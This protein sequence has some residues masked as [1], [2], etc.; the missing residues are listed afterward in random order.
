[1]PHSKA[2]TVS[3]RPEEEMILCCARTFMEP[4]RVERANALSRE[5]LDWAYLLETASRHGVAALV[6]VN[7]KTLCPDAVPKAT[8]A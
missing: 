2:V 3:F 5:D 8:L 1:M 6:Y 7:L 4:E